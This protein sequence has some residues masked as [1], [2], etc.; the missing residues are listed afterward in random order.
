ML[1]LEIIGNLGRDAE[2]VKF[3]DRDGRV[4]DYVSFSVA[5]TERRGGEPVTVWVSVL[6]YGN[7]GGV[8]PYLKRGTK[9]FVRG[10][11]TIKAYID[12]NGKPA[13]AI[14]CRASEVTLCGSSSD[15]TGANAGAPAAAAPASPAQAEIFPPS[16]ARRSSRQTAAPTTGTP[17]TTVKD[18]D[19][20]PF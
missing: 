11:Q 10:P 16:P 19:D 15:G 8:L 14:N 3:N 4:T 17:S 20:L 9:V 5:H 13:S 2:V 6:W 18:D 7:G 1:Q 12:K